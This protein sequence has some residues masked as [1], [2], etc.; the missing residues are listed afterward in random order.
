MN[1]W[2]G[3]LIFVAI[4]VANVILEQKQQK[5]KKAAQ[6]PATPATPAAPAPPV[7][8]RA[9]VQRRTEPQ[10]SRPATPEPTLQEALQSLF[11]NSMLEPQA[12]MPPPLPLETSKPVVRVVDAATPRP[13]PAQPPEPPSPP[14]PPEPP[15]PSA[16]KA[17]TPCLLSKSDFHS[18]A[19]LR[20]AV[21][22]SEILAKP[23]SL[24]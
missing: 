19:S 7:R 2:F 16:P 23:K 6:R 12:E 21:I 10:P 22:M 1:D 15:M 24:Q 9:P 13:V 18:R 20:R 8:K 14:Q 11:E 3:I 17:Q 4:A 5:K